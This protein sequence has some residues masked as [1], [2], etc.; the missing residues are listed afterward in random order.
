MMLATSSQRALVVHL[1]LAA[2]LLPLSSSSVE[3]A[4]ARCMDQLAALDRSIAL[5]N[6][7]PAGVTVGTTR[8]YT[9][10]NTYYSYVCIAAGGQFVTS[11]YVRTCV[12]AY[13]VSTTSVLGFP[14]CYGA[15]CTSDEI[16]Y[17]YNTVIIPYYISDDLTRYGSECTFD[18]V[19][20]K[21][22][23]VTAEPTTSGITT[24][25]PAPSPTTPAAGSPPTTSASPPTVP[26]AAVAAPTPAA[27]TSAAGGG[28]IVASKFNNASGGPPHP[29]VSSAAALAVVALLTVISYY[30]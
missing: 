4:S 1:L 28:D 24:A 3:W 10:S 15:A 5:Q 30:M 25:A 14:S 22:G 21:F 17:Y 2:A 8:D 20:L 19:T 23:T 18:Q 12:S 7:I 13:A 16:F 29:A 26:T 6:A 27:P 9:D 11:T